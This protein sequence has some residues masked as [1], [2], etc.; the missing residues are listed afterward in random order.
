MA[1][2]GRS[3]APLTQGNQA[4]RAIIEK[5][6]L[7]ATD[8]GELLAKDGTLPAYGR[9]SPTLRK[10]RRRISRSGNPAWIRAPPVAWPGRPNRTCPR[11]MCAAPCSPEPPHARQASAA[12]HARPYTSW[13]EEGAGARVRRCPWLPMTWSEDAAGTLAETFDGTYAAPGVVTAAACIDEAGTAIRACPGDMPA[14]GR[15]EIGSI[16]K[17]MTATLLALLE[18]DGTLALNDEVSRWLPASP[19]SRITLR[20]LATHTSGLPRLAPN[21]GEADPANPY[22]RFGP[23]QAEEGLRQAVLAPGRPHLYS[24]FG[25]QL[26][27]LVL[28]RA[29]G[30]PYQE[31]ISH[32][33]LEPLAMTCSGSG[34]SGGGTPL[35][36]HGN[37]GEVPR[38]DQ[39]L[40]GAGGVEATIGD[41]AR[42]TRACLHPPQDPLGA[43]IAAAQAPQF[44]LETAAARRSPGSSGKTA[45][46]STRR[47]R[48]VHLRHPHRPRPLPRR[49]HAGQLRWRLAARPRCSPGPCRRRSPRGPP[50]AARTRMGRP[51]PRDH[52]DAARRAGRGRPRA[53][54]RR[55]PGPGIPRAARPGLA[56]V[57]TRP[58]PGDRG[59][60]QLPG[61]AD[62]IAADVTVT[63]AS[64][65]RAGQIHFDS[66]RQIAGLRFPPPG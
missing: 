60:G 39:P 56:R 5:T 16:T 1:G 28:E 61:P 45:S 15:F 58:R 14:D 37:D 50:S 4:G 3:A 47:D 23:V 46:A 66:S 9:S 43:A 13:K 40:P 2:R 17:T 59:P 57:D 29:S 34:G 30:L 44:P 24:N 20:Q 22:A 27:G 48:R 38:W 25:Y 41:L 33:L 31:L 55:V 64:G 63:F 6:R 7:G 52:P 11:G 18:A 54:D 51:R 32:R 21:H 65:S 12:E 8:V 42:Y 10:A 26:L 36:G 19:E 49:R 62:F 53:H 35:P